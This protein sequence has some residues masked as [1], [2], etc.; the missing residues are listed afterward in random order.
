MRNTN[1]KT[2]TTVRDSYNSK[3]EEII[4]KTGRHKACPYNKKENIKIITELN[5]NVDS[6]RGTVHRAQIYK[7]DIGLIIKRNEDDEK[8]YNSNR[9]RACRM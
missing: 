8:L 7:N 3:I 4:D 1:L 6:C 9:W 2:I 5:K